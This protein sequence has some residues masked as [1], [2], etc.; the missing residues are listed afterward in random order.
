MPG[1]VPPLNLSLGSGASSGPTQ[2]GATNGG[3]MGS[4]SSGD[5]IIPTNTGSG[6]IS[7]ATGGQVN[8]LY[9]AVA[10]AAVWFLRK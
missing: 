7:T 4:L 3:G 5:W 8:W 10:A 6:S 1:L 2:G 9:V